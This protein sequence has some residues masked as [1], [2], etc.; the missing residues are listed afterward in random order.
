VRGEDDVV[1]AALIDQV[2][3]GRAQRRGVTPIQIE[4]VLRVRYDGQREPRVL[5]V[6]PARSNQPAGRGSR[7]RPD[8]RAADDS[9]C[10]Q[11]PC[12]E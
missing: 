3:E 11:H 6:G 5:G 2:L 8:H 10:P 7:R 4:Q 1:H 12:L 9:T